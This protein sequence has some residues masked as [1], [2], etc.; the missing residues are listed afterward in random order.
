MKSALS[1]IL[2][3]CSCVS[4]V[5]SMRNFS[6][7][8]ALWSVTDMSSGFVRWCHVLGLRGGVYVVASTTGSDAK[9]HEIRS[10]LRDTGCDHRF[11]ENGIARCAWL[12]AGAVEPVVQDSRLRGR[13]RGEHIH[14]G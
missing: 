3:P 11:V 4:A 1:E 2:T 8:A 6:S 12:G 14:D 7:R 9:P 10:P 5:R 13:V